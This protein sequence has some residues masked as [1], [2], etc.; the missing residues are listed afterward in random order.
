MTREEALNIAL[1]S[2]TSIPEAIKQANMLLA[3]VSG[4]YPE[5]AVDEAGTVPQD[6][7]NFKSLAGTP[8]EKVFALLLGKKATKVRWN[9][10][11]VNILINHIRGKERSA[12][13]HAGMEIGCSV[14][15]CAVQTYRLRSSGLANKEE[16]MRLVAE[17]RSVLLGICGE[18]GTLR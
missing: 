6:L 4:K 18:T 7:P 12:L 3:Y 2:T 13:I 5:V 16:Y 8:E 10:R 9:E 14:K 11:N 15:A 1:S 17:A